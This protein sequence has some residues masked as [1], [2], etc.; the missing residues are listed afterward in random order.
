[1]IHLTTPDVKLEINFELPC[2]FAIWNTGIHFRGA[3]TDS[4]TVCRR[5]SSMPSF[6]MLSHRDSEVFWLTTFSFSRHVELSERMFY[7]KEEL[8]GHHEGDDYFE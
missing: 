3:S 1:M 2:L 7:C 8:Y 6:L 5:I 4:F